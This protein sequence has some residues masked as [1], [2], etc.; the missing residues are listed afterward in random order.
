MAL[1]N[2]RQCDFLLMRY[3]PDPLK[4][5]FV[6]IGVLLFARDDAF[7][8]VRFTRDWGRVR[9]LDP[10][11]DVDILEALENDIREQLQSNA[12]SRNQIVHR[13]QDT[14]SNGLQITEPKALLSISPE[15]DLDELAKTY[16]ERVLPKREARPGARQRIVAHMQDAFERAGVWNSINKKISA[17]RY[18]RP[19]DPL[20]ID[21]GYRPNGVIR[22]FHALSLATEP[23]SAKILA[24]SYPQLAEGIAR[25]E[26]AKTD[27]TAV[28]E[29][30]LDRTDEAIQFAVEAL[31][32]T[33]IHVVGVSQMHDLAERARVE[34]RL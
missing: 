19:G 17:S 34:L 13:L 28:V 2:A 33:S 26:H 6:N 14:L 21:C 15:H 11:A 24:F 5:E 25:V 27:F 22:L 9:C 30:D 4:N 20:K 10:Q 8:G 16:L 12:E 18:T 29:D 23:D 3:V 31:E 32:K 1:D 7:A